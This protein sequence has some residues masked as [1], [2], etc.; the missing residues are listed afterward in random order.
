MRILFICDW[1]YTLFWHPIARQMKASGL[2]TEC[3]AL[4]VG[5]LY[6]DKLIAENDGVF[7]RIF[8]LQ[9]AVEHVPD[10]I[11]DLD[12]KL[13]EIQARY[14]EYPLWRYVW[15]DRSWVNCGYDEARRRLLVCFEYYEKLYAG[16]RPDLIVTNG[17]A[18]MPHLV[19]FEVARKQGRRIVR[20]L[21]IR[22]EDRFILSDNAMEQESWIDDYFA[23]RRQ[24]SDTTRVEVDSFLKEFRAGGKKPDYFI[25]STRAHVLTFGHAYRFFRYVYRYWF[26]GY[27]GDH[28]KINPFLRLVSELTWRIRRARY[29]RADRWDNYDSSERYVYFPL[30]VQPEMSTMVLAP[31]YLD[32]PSVLENLSKSLPVDCRLLVKEHPSMLGRRNFDYYNRIRRL[33]NVRM[34]SPFADSFRIIENAAAIVTI[35]GTVGLE[36]LILKK[37]VIVLGAAYYRYC[38][39]VASGIDVPPTQWSGLIR[40]A[41]DNYRYDENVLRTFLGAVFEH[42]FRGTYTEP[43]AALEKVIA[44]DNMRILIEQISSFAEAGRYHKKFIK[45]S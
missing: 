26:G 15:A 38:P 31:Y 3:V 11:A 10:Q 42:S 20:H 9:D 32:Q 45:K 30:H 19:S 18:S 13:L 41:L 36:G 6:Y 12:A 16:E 40:S 22:L 34:V 37:P 2:A 8:L 29:T 43:L 23:G 14:A 24:V 21:S 27:K 33:P 7:D 35:T 28:T 25:L 39:L 4:V 1:D 44:P 17:Y 5:R